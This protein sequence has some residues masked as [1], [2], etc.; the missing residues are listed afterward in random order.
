V[1]LLISFLIFLLAIAGTPLFVGM[2]LS[3]RIAQER[4]KELLASSDDYF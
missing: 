2:T 1:S 4:A 3:N